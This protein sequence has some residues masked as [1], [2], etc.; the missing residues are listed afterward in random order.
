M[1]GIIRTTVMNVSM[2]TI[3]KYIKNCAEAERW[4]IALLNSVNVYE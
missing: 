4:N 2:T 3:K 1:L